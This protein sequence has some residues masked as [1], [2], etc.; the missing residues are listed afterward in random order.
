MYCV[1]LLVLVLGPSVGGRLQQLLG[2]II[3][4]PKAS[5]Q[6]AAASRRASTSTRSRDGSDDSEKVCELT[7]DLMHMNE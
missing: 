4:A 2:K 6:T 1:Y 7:T 3:R 5:K